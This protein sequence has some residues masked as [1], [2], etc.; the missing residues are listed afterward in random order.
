MA[1]RRGRPQ[2]RSRT[3]ADRAQ[4]AKERKEEAKKIEL[5]N[6]I[7]KTMLGKKVKNGEITSLEE[8][9][10]ANKKILEPEIIDF[11]IPELEEKLVD[12][13]KTTKVRRAGRMFSFRAA[14]LVGDR[15]QFVGF[16]TAKDRER[17]PAIR[18]ATRKAKLHLTKVR[19][20]NGSWESTSV[21]GASVPFKVKGKSSSV[22]VELIPAPEGTGLVCGDKI[23]DV[24]KF[25]GI[26]DVWSR[27]YGSTSSTIDFV[28]AAINALSKTTKMKLSP[29]IEEKIKRS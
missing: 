13:T 26:K 3:Q 10:D 1:E 8:V 5:E 20:G 17:W 14:V 12:F 18:K 19:K 25:V 9:F 11:L 27:T 23:K 2:G 4:R 6:W 29:Q 21:T 22:R 15:R 28:K 16:G 24:M 7:P